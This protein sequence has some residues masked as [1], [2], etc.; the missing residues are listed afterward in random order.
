VRFPNRAFSDWVFRVQIRAL[1][2]GKTEAVAGGVQTLFG[3]FAHAS[4]RMVA[5]IPPGASMPGEVLQW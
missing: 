5:V 4:A 3:L 1:T 2:T